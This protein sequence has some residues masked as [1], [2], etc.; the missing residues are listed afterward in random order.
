MLRQGTPWDIA[1]AALFLASDES[2][3]ITGADLPIDGGLAI[4]LD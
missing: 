3:Y 4:L 1:Y 2:R